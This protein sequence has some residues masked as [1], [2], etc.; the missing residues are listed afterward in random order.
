MNGYVNGGL[1]S[2]II[3]L[4]RIDFVSYVVFVSAIRI[5][6]HTRIR[7]YHDYL[8]STWL[9][10]GILVFRYSG[11]IIDIQ[12]LTRSEWNIINVS[13]TCRGYVIIAQISG[14]ITWG[15]QYLYV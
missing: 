12:R 14:I 13:I 10:I 1:L 9:G 11:I 15:K 3:I 4:T 2:V 6:L 5:V 7:T 8:I